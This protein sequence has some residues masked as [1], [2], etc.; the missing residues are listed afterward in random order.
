ML[1]HYR[2]RFPGCKIVV[3]DNISTDNTVKI[4]LA[5]DCEVI[6]YDTNGQLQDSRYLKIKNNYWKNAKTDWVLMCD[7][8]ELLDI[9]AKVLQAEEN[10][11]TTII[12]SE[13]Y[14]MINLK[15]NFDLDG[16]KYGARD[17]N[18]DKFCLFN[19]RFIKEINYS[20]GC[21]GCNPT[22]TIK[23]SKKT[24]KL[25]HYSSICESFTLEKHKR[26]KARLSPENI[27]NG[28]G[29]HYFSDYTPEQAHKDHLEERSKAVKVR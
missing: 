23:Y 16:M 19:K 7:M 18:Y 29:S 24:Y 2:E 27:K 12:R 20:I 3:Y 17:I 5:N 1:D 15:D 25:Y 4:A 11:G 9:N 8:D 14:E 26:Y 22:G 28:W 13:G 10:A 6:S 21:H